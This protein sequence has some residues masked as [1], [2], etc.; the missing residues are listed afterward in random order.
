MLKWLNKSL[1]WSV[2]TIILFLIS[3]FLIKPFINETKQE[4]ATMNNSAEISRELRDMELLVQQRFVI[5]SQYI[6][7][8]ENLMF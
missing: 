5:L 4:V 8:P 7:A 2:I 6:V 1:Y 3:A